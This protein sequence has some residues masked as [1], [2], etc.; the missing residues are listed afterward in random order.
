MWFQLYFCVCFS[1]MERV[2]RISLEEEDQPHNLP[3]PVIDLT[4]EENI[5]DS[6]GFSNSQPESAAILVDAKPSTSNQDVIDLT[7]E[8]EVANTIINISNDPRAQVSPVESNNDFF[9]DPI[10]NL[11]EVTERI[12]FSSD[13]LSTSH[14]DHS[15][16]RPVDKDEQPMEIDTD[17]ISLTQTNVSENMDFT[18]NSNDECRSKMQELLD[19]IVITESNRDISPVDGKIQGDIQV[20]GGTVMSGNSHKISLSSHEEKDPSDGKIQGD[21][22][23]EVDTVTPENSYEI[24]ISSSNKEKS[25]SD[26]KIQE[27]KQAKEGA[28]I[29]GNFHKI[30]SLS[31]NKEK[32][33][34]DDNIHKDMQVEAGAFIPGNYHEINSPSSNREKSLSNDKI[35]EGVQVEVG[36]VILGNSHLLTS[37]S[38]CNETNPSNGKIQENKQAKECALIPGN[39]QKINSQSSNKEKSPCDG[40]IHKDMQVEVEAG[41]PGI[42]HKITSPSSNKELSP[43]EGKIQEDTQA[44]E[45]ALNFHKINS[46]SRNKEKSP[47]DGNIQEDMQVEVEAGVPENS[48][49]ITSPLSNKETSPSDGKI[50]EDTQVEEDALIPINSHKINSPS[51]NKEKGSSGGNIQEDTK[52][53]IDAGAPRIFHK[54]DS[55][56]NNKEKSSSNDKIQEDIQVEVSDATPGNFHKIKGPSSNKE[57]S[58]SDGKIQ[59]DNINPEKDINVLENS[60]KGNRT[61][62]EEPTQ[63]YSTVFLNDSC[64]TPSKMPDSVLSSLAIAKEIESLAKL[65][66]EKLQ[67][68]EITSNSTST[69]RELPIVNESNENIFKENRRQNYSIDKES[70]VKTKEK[71]KGTG[72][73]IL[74]QDKRFPC[75]NL[76]GDTVSS[77][78]ESSKS[79]A[80][81]MS[82]F[83][84]TDE[85]V[86]DETNTAMYNQNAAKSIDLHNKQ[87]ETT[88]SDSSNKASQNV[89]EIELNNKIKISGKNQNDTV[90]TTD[91]DVNLLI[92][93]VHNKSVFS[94]GISKLQKVSKVSEIEREGS[95]SSTSEILEV[96][97]ETSSKLL[98]NTLKTCDTELKA[99]VPLNKTS[100]NPIG[101]FD[102]ASIIRQEMMKML[103][104]LLKEM[105]KINTGDFHVLFILNP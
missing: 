69:S 12:L 67:N 86:V 80:D 39:S 103:P 14:K 94:S 97:N 32:S 64:K 73:A 28:L 2:N 37:P 3:P 101:N 50:Q 65:H 41:I 72:G 98:E 76:A 35:H 19:V 100:K 68:R 15:E 8:Q 25:T 7:T 87:A 4:F 38:S 99:D 56:S 82:Q 24:N 30:N 43:S 5:D 54:I 40:N 6:N 83:D 62:V 60:R 79:Q 95:V 57:K 1:R 88:E 13:P 27:D 66:K 96:A 51:S 104:D 31:S 21:L 45:G 10:K 48:C 36:T 42:S 49:K 55:S 22:L 78:K 9:V 26:G 74:L 89:I 44:E 90:T 52:M 20:V 61:D 70:V 84:L 81:S 29:P 85:L 92:E 71:E 23:V 34:S 17:E 93:E 91:E 53:K 58:P 75:S 33:P 102:V 77:T 18:V 46:P 16:Q 105:Q 47:D 59:K 63:R 11:A